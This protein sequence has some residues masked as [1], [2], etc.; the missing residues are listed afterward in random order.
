MDEMVALEHYLYEDGIGVSINDMELWVDRIVVLPKIRPHKLEKAVE[1][2]FL[3]CQN[4]DFRRKLLERFKECY[5][6]IYHLLKSNIFR[7]EEIEPFLKPRN[8]DLYFCYFWKEI[9]TFKESFDKSIRSYGIDTAFFKNEI[10]M[11]MWIKYGFHPSCIEYCLKYDIIEDVVDFNTIPRAVKWSPFEWSLKP[12][13]LGTLSFSGF[14]GS[15]KCFKYLLLN[16]FN[17]ESTV[18]SSVVSSGC[19]DLFHL[20]RGQKNT[21]S[22]II[23]TASIFYHPSLLVFLFE[24]GVYHNSKGK[25]NW[26]N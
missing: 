10:D 1:Y 15:I 6:L 7:I 8:N 24:N 3:L 21:Y 23:S 11:A 12:D 4:Q 13:S 26:R 18:L 9:E 2:C 25:I 17:F 16:G 19:L 22:E 5:V 14:F 20:Y